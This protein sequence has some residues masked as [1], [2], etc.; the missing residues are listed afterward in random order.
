MLRIRALGWFILVL[1]L[2]SFD[3]WIRLPEGD[4]M[5]SRASNGATKAR[6]F[7]ENTIMFR[8]VMTKIQSVFNTFAVWFRSN[9]AD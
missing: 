9:L 8:P 6:Q 5:G 1:I 3:G 7:V 4:S 2:Q